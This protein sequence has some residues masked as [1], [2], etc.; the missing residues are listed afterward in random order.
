[1]A[2]KRS[3][4]TVGNGM[5]TCRF[6]DE[7]VARDAQEMYDI[8]VVGDE[9]AGAYNRVMLGKVLKGAEPDAVITKPRAWYAE[10]GIRLVAPARADRIDVA[11][12]RVVLNDAEALHY[13]IA[14][15]AT[16]SQPIMPGIDGVHNDSGEPKEGVF[17]YR[18]I[19]DCL[20]IR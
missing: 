12:R 6:L 17:V 19:N 16:G 15:L 14:I 13:D 18:T 3:L 9:P 4:V 20:S 11:E 2:R 1:M 10:R 5:A 7:F 8:T